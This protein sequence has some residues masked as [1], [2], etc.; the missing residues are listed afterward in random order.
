MPTPDSPPSC[1]L[2]LAGIRLASKVSCLVWHPD[3]EGVVTCA[4]YDGIVS[5]VHVS[6]GHLMAE[7]DGHSG[8]RVWSV[9]H[10]RL[11]RDLCVSTSDDGTAKLWSGRHLALCAG[12]I[13]PPG[14]ASICG[15]DFSTR[16]ENMLAVASSDCNA[17]IYDLRNL[18]QP[19][20]R[21]SGHSRPVSYVKFR[22]SD[23]SLITAGIDGTI[24]LWGG[25]HEDD[26]DNIQRIR[27][28][29]EG[30][31]SMEVRKSIEGRRSIEG[32][33]SMERRRSGDARNRGSEVCTVKPRKVFNGHR[34]E[35]NFVGL[36]VHEEQGLMAC[37]SET[38]HAHVYHHFWSDPVLVFDCWPDEEQAAAPQLHTSPPILPPF[39]SC[40]CWQ[41]HMVGAPPTLAAATSNGKIQVV[42][43]RRE[44]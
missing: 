34:N 30:R 39:V 4:D 24:L 29:M 36:S 5:Q 18:R 20:M 28:S 41:P 13:D 17:Y 44:Q 32:R 12:T 11:R 14:N 15:C 7:V 26:K 1:S 22:P 43:L 16:D 40:V 6:T 31:R 33:C 38:S 25:G 8:R 23:D 42:A 35:K 19:M 9:C 21:F 37:G 3:Q 27:K 10:S 2:P